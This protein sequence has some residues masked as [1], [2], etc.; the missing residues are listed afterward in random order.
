VTVAS[1][2]SDVAISAKSRVLAAAT[3]A[4]LRLEGENIE[5]GA[6]GTIE[7]KGAKK[8]WNPPVETHA[9]SIQLPGTSLNDEQF[10]LKDELSGEPL[11]GIPSRIELEDG[12]EFRGLT[13]TNGRTERAYTGARKQG[14]S[15]HLDD[16]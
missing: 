14:V 3:G 16:E 2:Q 12:T 9:R 6:P 11:S 8:A 5:L 7:F 15:I 10:V 4:Y 13:D 1:T